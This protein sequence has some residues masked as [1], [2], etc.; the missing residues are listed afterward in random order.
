MYLDI[1]SII[2]ERHFH[3]LKV[4]ML[5]VLNSNCISEVFRYITTTTRQEV[6]NHY[7]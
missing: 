3:L 1:V 6:L 4:E 5:I 2:D 7:I